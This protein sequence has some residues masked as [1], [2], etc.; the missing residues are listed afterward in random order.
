MEGYHV[1]WG[2][3]FLWDLW[4]FVA[5]LSIAIS[6]GCELK[7]TSLRWMGHREA[8]AMTLR[9]SGWLSQPKTLSVFPVIS[10][11]EHSGASL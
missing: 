8:L 3:T 10:G 5:G 7:R 11:W 9:V 4:M 1:E 6:R 2:M